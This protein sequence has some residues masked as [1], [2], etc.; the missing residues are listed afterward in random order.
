MK[1]PVAIIQSLLVLLL[2]LLLWGCATHE[3]ANPHVVKQRFVP[4]PHDPSS[5]SGANWTAL[6]PFPDKRGAPHVLAHAGIGD[7]F[8]VQEKG[9]PTVFQVL[10]VEGDD[11]HLILEIRSEETLKRIDLPRDKSVSVQISG[12]RYEFCY[13]TTHVNPNEKL[14]TS[15]AFLIVKRCQP[16]SKLNPSDGK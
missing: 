7:T 6:V 8:P 10:V 12:S 5:G 9:G 13:P 2:G 16:L 1:A 11:A 15:K 4:M 3:A 14:T